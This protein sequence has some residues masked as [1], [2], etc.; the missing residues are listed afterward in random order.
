MVHESH[1]SWK[2]G[3]LHIISKTALLPRQYKVV[4]IDKQWFT[5]RTGRG[6]MVTCISLVRQLFYL[7]SRRSSGLRNNG[8][9]V[10]QLVNCIHN[11]KLRTIYVPR[12]KNVNTPKAQ[13]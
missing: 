2:N 7:D 11:D 13:K 10:V 12:S 4:W 9:R 6:T 8:L 5:S 3:D 1:S